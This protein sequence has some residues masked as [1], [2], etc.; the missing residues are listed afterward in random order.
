MGIVF[1]AVREKDGE[2]VAL[3]VLRDELAGDELYRRRFH[4][5]GRIAREVVHRHIVPVVDFGEASGRLY[6]ATRFV[7]GASLAE[8]IAAQGA[9][10]VAE[11][12]RLASDLGA[13]LDSIHARGLVHRDVKPAN[14]MIDERGAAALTDFGLARGIADT[15]LTKTGAVVGTVD[16]LAPEIIRGQPASRSSDIYA[17]GCLL[18]ESLAGAAP[19][20]DKAYVDALLAH[21]R[22]EP[23][24]LSVFRAD[25]P[26]GLSWTV[27]T[28]LAK[29]PGERPPTATA[30][31]RLVRTSA[32]AG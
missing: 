11:A 25:V 24:D 6:I 4:R 18:Y 16:Y 31:A 27:L 23:L 10:P 15:V 21:V 30:F 32:K 22:Q 29:D 26:A 19:F 3:K 9:L 20:A 5:E 8:R 12:L 1:R 2:T 17:F 7:R 14:V 13:G 28:A